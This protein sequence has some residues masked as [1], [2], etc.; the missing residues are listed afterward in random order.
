MVLALISIT[1]FILRWMWICYESTLSTHRFTHILPHIIDTL[2][3]VS[4][5]WL[6]VSIRQY[7]FIDAWLTAKIFGLIV[8]I[9]LGSYALKR[10]T[11]V[12]SRIMA[13]AGSLLV[14]V[15]IISVARLK[16]SWGFLSL[17]E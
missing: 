11:T 3:F 17:L 14:F 2:F 15:W 5:V 9:T 4:G 6:A 16:S 8:Y 7:P 1:G 13:F 12:Q 10:A